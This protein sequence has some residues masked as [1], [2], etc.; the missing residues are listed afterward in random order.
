MGAGGGSKRN[1]KVK[2]DDRYRGGVCGMT[3]KKTNRRRNKERIKIMHE[4]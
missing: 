4:V 1:T 2:I 3:C